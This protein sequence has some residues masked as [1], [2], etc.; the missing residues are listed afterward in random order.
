MAKDRIT[1]E[2]GTKRRGHIRALEVAGLLHVFG[3]PEMYEEIP[4]VESEIYFITHGFSCADN[5][6]VTARKSMA[7]WIK[8]MRNKRLAYYY[9]GKKQEGGK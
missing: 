3:D 6:Y 9:N 5:C 1:N 8:W 2:D 4:N 7:K